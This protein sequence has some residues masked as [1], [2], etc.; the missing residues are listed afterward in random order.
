[1]PHSGQARPQQTG[2]QIKLYLVMGVDEI[3]R[4]VAYGKVLRG[5]TFEQLYRATRLFDVKQFV[6]NA[7]FLVESLQNGLIYIFWQ[8]VKP[9][10]MREELTSANLL[11]T[12]KGHLPSRK[13]HENNTFRAQELAQLGQERGLIHNVF[14]Y[15]VADNQVEMV[16]NILHF[17]HV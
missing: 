4:A 8:E 2:A 7:W 12:A 1:M 15:V 11:M 17:E 3:K 14:D 6:C 10:Q 13:R 5:Q 9:R 16:F